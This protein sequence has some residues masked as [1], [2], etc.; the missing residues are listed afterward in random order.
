MECLPFDCSEFIGIR[1][2]L[3]EQ[4]EY[5]RYEGWTLLCGGELLPFDR[6]REQWRWIS[7]RKVFGPVPIRSTARVIEM[8]RPRKRAAR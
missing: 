2:G 3:A 4:R 5:D 6:W 1:R 8:A 7:Q